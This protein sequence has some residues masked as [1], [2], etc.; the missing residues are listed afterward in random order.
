MLIQQ[1][2]YAHIT[3]SVGEAIFVDDIPSPINCLY[4]A[5]VYSTKPLVRIRSVEI[6]SK[7]LPGVSAFL[8]YKDIP[9]AGQNIGSRTKFG[10]EPL[11]ADELTHCA[12]QPI[13]FVVIYDFRLV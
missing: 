4:G 10:P 3:T 5:F 1:K 2:V 8:S 12:G 13:A 6:K 9:E 7:S 11:F